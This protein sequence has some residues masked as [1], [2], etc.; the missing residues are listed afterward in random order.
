MESGKES[1]QREKRSAGLRKAAL[2]ILASNSLL[3][4]IKALGGFIGN[5][6]AML[7]DA[8]NSL[9]DVFT[10]ALL[11]VGL[12]WASRPVDHDHHYGHGR[13]EDLMANLVGVFLTAFGPYLL[14]RAVGSAWR[15]K[16]PRP[17][18]LAAGLAVTN[19]VLKSGMW[20]FAYSV[21]RRLRSPAMRAV[22]TDFLSDVLISLA[23]VGGVIGAVIRWPYLDTVLSVPVAIMV[24]FFGVRLYR[25]SVHVLMDG[26]PPSEL[27]EKAASLAERVP[28]VGRVHA[29]RGR[30][31]GGETLLDVDIEVD[32]HLTVDQGHDIAHA[33]ER[34]ILE[35]MEE[36]ASVNVHVN[37]FPHSHLEPQE[38]EDEGPPERS[39]S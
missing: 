4:V 10:S 35:F 21:G 31:S 23:I 33:V 26:V 7:A 18:A 17:N 13:V 5:S 30:Q 14:Y 11:I 38:E 3:V 6:Q 34:A 12:A 16:F 39:P 22:A 36:V 27:V 37:P 19:C 2:L 24:T 29:I 25:K 9:G 20:G 32:P 15:G 28:G 8:A 1:I